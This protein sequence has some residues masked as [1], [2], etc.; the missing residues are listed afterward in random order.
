MKWGDKVL[1]ASFL[2]FYEALN[3]LSLHHY[4]FYSELNISIPIHFKENHHL[5]LSL[6]G[7][8]AL[9]PLFLKG[10]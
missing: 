8:V 1:K 4:D 2:H 9:A 6:T 3:D 7:G 10:L 5:T